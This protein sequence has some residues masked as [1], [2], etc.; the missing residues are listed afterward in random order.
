MIVTEILGNTHEPSGRQ[1][2]GD[3]H[4]ERVVLPGPAL[5][6]RI[7][8]LTT[9]HGTELGL[10]L[11]AGAAPDPAELPATGRGYAVVL[12]GRL[13]D[14]DRDLPAGT[15]V[16]IDRPAELG[17]LPAAEDAEVVVCLFAAAG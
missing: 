13:R 11:P 3:R 9:D 7:Q 10:R 4:V 14:G 16:A 8:R 5:V 15:V 1:L 12:T 17:A 6:K 2:V